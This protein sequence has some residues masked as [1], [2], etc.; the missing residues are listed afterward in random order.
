MREGRRSAQMGKKGQSHHRWMVGG[1]VCFILNQGG[2]LGAWDGATAHGHDTHVQPL[3]AQCADTMIV[4]TDTGLHAQ[5]G[6]PINMPVGPRGT[7]HTRMVVE[8]VLSRLTTVCQS[9][10]VGHR[11]WTYFRA[12]VAWTMAAFNRLARWG[13]EIDD[14]DMVCL[15]IAEFSLS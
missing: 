12:R 15:S 5:T 11:V 2:W 10:K 3:I 7:W 14:E 4:L 6:D 13:L 1:T 8:T 9:T